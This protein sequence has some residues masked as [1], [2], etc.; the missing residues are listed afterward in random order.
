MAMNYE[1]MAV[2]RS[3]LEHAPKEPGPIADGLIGFAMGGHFIC[4]TCSGR[5]C[6][7]GCSHLLRGSQP[8]W[9]DD[10][11]IRPGWSCCLC[12]E[13]HPHCREGGE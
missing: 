7:R 4:S 8:V 2:L 5:L 13:L 10:T 3:A 6:G 12:G 11:P 1:T 9:K